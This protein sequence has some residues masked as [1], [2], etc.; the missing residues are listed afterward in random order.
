MSSCWS[1]PHLV[2]GRRQSPDRTVRRLRFEPMEPRIMLAADLDV[3]APGLSVGATGGMT[4]SIGGSVTVSTPQNNCAAHDDAP[5][6]TA[7]RMQLIDSTGTLVEE[8]ATDAQG[9]YQFRDLIP[10]DY[11]VRLAPAGAELSKGAAPALFSIGS[12]ELQGG[13]SLTGFDFC[14]SQVAT[15]ATAPDPALLSAVLGSVVLG[16]AQQ[17]TAVEIMQP[18]TFVAVATPNNAQ[19]TP[20]LAES[21]ADFFYGGSSRAVG[22]R[23]SVNTWDD[24]PA[25]DLSATLRLIDA[26]GGAQL[27]EGLLTDDEEASDAAFA[28]GY[29]TKSLDWFDTTSKTV[30]QDVL[31]GDSDLAKDSAEQPAMAAPKLASRAGTLSE[32]R[33]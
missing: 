15:A 25:A 12:I 19:P 24:F 33:Q 8:T 32:Q 10:G 23:K 27:V 16:S 13:E 30:V 20:L 11:T 26:S 18:S 3:G 7:V 6:M 9:R 29:T 17:P 5:K 28:D 4:G 21:G 1:T 22:G 31:G 14:H 2:G